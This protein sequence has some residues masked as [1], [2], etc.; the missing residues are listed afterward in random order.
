MAQIYNA[1]C[2]ESCHLAHDWQ[3]A[4]VLGTA[5]GE[6]EECGI[7]CQKKQLRNRAKF[8]FT[9]PKTAGTL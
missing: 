7:N 4:M 6:D 8:F 3:K 1:Y 9:R 2:G 5:S